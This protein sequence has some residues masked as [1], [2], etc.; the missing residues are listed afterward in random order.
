MTTT[1][2]PSLLNRLRRIKIIFLDVDGVLTDGSIILIPGG[3]EQKVFD[4]KDG[5]GIVWASWVGLEV[6]LITGR[7][8]QVLEERA[9]ELKIGHLRQKVTDKVVAAQEILAARGLT[10]EEAAAMGDDYGDIQLLRRVAFAAC[11]ADA[12]PDVAR[13]CAWKSRHRGG[14]GAVR[15][16]IER[17]IRAQGLMPLVRARYGLPQGGGAATGRSSAPPGMRATGPR[18][19]H[20]A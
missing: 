17:I 7:R 8:S 6:G 2:Q 18:R 3:D 15:E 1:G 12:H 19:G 16:L 13:I 14:G 10:F 9:K 20:R 5:T 4:V 11:P